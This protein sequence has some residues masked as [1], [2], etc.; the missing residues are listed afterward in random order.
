MG[1]GVAS[2]MAKPSRNASL[3]STTQVALPL[4][5]AVPETRTRQARCGPRRSAAISSPWNGTPEAPANARVAPGMIRPRAAST[6]IRAVTPL[7]VALRSIWPS[8]KTQKWREGRGEAGGASS[9]R[10]TL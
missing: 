10:M 4:K 7:P 2:S 8:P 3:S 1:S 9:V 5:D 6:A